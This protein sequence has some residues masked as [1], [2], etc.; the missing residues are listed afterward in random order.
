MRRDGLR[1]LKAGVHHVRTGGRDGL[2]AVERFQGIQEHV[3]RATSLVV[4]GELPAA[5]A[6]GAG[7]REQLLRGD[8]QLPAVVRVGLSIQLL[9]EGAVG[10]AL[11]G[12]ADGH[13]AVERHFEGAEFQP[14][15]AGVGGVWRCLDFGHSLFGG[16]GSVQ[17]PGQDGP[18]G[19]PSLRLEFLPQGDLGGVDRA[20]PD[21]SEPRRHV[22]LEHRLE[23]GEFVLFREGIGPVQS[24]EQVLRVLEDAVRLARG[25]AHDLAARRVGRVAADA[26]DLEPQRIDDHQVAGVE[27]HRVVGRHVQH[28]A[29]GHAQFLQARGEGAGDHD[30]AALG[31]LARLLPDVGLHGGEGIERRQRAAKLAQRRLERVHVAVDQPGQHRAALE[32]DHAGAGAALAR[33]HV[34][35][36]SHRGDPAAL[37]RHGLAHGEP[38]VHGHD[39]AVMQDQVR[40]GARRQRRGNE[41]QESIPHSPSLP[42]QHTEQ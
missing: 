24:F 1:A 9:A 42:R 38:R 26:A 30:P 40:V 41:N 3:D 17:P 2:L 23:R 19:Q 11:V 8:E 5:R 34:A 22:P 4:G 7:Q 20:L 37:H 14:L 25:V 28:V 27:H 12:R 15:V 32:V 10:V 6:G 18:D 13:A 16:L 21:G 39:L 29:R 31:G 35:I 36:G 33:Q